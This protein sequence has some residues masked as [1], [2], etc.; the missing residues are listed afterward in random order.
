MPTASPPRVFD[1]SKLA[2]DCDHCDAICCV[3]TKLPHDSYPKPA[4][5]PCKHLDPTMKRCSIFETLEHHGFGFCRTFDC[6]GG[7]VA[8]AKLFRELGRN[9][10]SDPTIANAQFDVFSIVYF[11]LVKY[12]HPDRNIDIDVP[13]E[14]IAELKPLIDAALALLAAESDPFKALEL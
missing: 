5:I 6:Y 14:R 9:W 2:A 3:A 1:K 4:R 8:V 13:E 12:L 7:G 10:V 11:T